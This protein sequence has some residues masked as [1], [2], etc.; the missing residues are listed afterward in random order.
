MVLSVVECLNALF[1]G[2]ITYADVLEALPFGVTIDIVELA[3]EDLISVFEHSVTDYDPCSRHGKF[4]QVSG[5]KIN[6]IVL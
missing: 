2:D 4:L 6:H 1:V 3:G 5:M